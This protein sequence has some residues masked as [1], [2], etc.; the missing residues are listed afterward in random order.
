V[1]RSWTRIVPAFLALTAILAASARADPIPDGE[2]ARSVARAR[3]VERE[4]VRVLARVRQAA[5]TVVGRRPLPGGT[6][7]T[8]LGGVGSG[9]VVSWR[10]TW[11]VTN[12]HVV[13]EEPVV[14]AVTQD[15]RFHR[16]RL[17]ARD[18]RSDLA[19]LSF[20]RAPEGLAPYALDRDGEAEVREG[21]WVVATGS[22]FYL[23]LDGEAAASLGVVS[24][25]RPPDPEAYL[26]VPTL[27]HDAEINPGSSGGALWSSDGRLLGINGTIATRTDRRAG[28]P[29]HTGASFAVPVGA[30]RAFLTTTLGPARDRPVVSTA[31]AAPTQ[32]TRP[33]HLGVS[34]RTT[35]DRLGQPAGALV[36]QVARTSPAAPAPGRPGLRAGDL[37]TRFTA[38]GR[39]YRIRSAADVEYAMRLYPAGTPVSVAFYRAGRFLAWTGRLA[40]R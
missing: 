20:D 37:V 9:V 11:V 5:V 36:S 17:R 7:G 35:H 8:V 22:P 30:V 1:P 25:V 27:Q 18:R 34:F 32:R 31:P 3:A 26:D 12:Y 21:A 6:G 33:G 15:G 13:D 14:E 19:L 39:A 40:W 2:V 10:G 29:A 38:G 23:A 16:L 4:V 28:G 24:G